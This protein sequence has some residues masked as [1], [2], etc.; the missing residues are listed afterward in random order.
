MEELPGLSGYAVGQLEI[1]ACMIEEM[2]LLKYKIDWR[3]LQWPFIK[4]L[5]NNDLSRVIGLVPLAGYLI[6]LND[7]IARLASFDTLAGVTGNTDPTFL[8]GSV[9][10]LRFVFFGSLFV[11]ISYV[12]CRIWQPDVLDNYRSEIEFAGRVQENFTV[13]E[14]ASM[15]KQAFSENWQPRLADFWIILDS[16]RTAPVLLGWRPDVRRSML[17]KH[18]DYINLLAREWWVG[19]LHI[20]RSAR[21]AAFVFGCLGYF[22]LAVPTLDI[23]QAV[24]RDM[25]WRS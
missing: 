18:G 1:Y 2:Y 3:I 25:F 17:V 10:K 6:L 20:N 5:A 8:I 12:I 16:E 24:I 19:T 13:Q 9:T 21:L 14:I 23:A 4:G 11:F 22:L 7:E 15:E